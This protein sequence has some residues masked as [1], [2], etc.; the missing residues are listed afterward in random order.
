LRDDEA[1]PLILGMGLPLIRKKFPEACH[2]MRHD[3]PKDVIEVLPRVHITGLAGLNQP[4]EKGR[5]PGASLTSREEPV[6][7]FMRSSA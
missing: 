5:G 7:P 4:K 6:L 1:C 3:P 2:W